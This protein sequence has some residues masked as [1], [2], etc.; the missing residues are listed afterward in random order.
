M[1]KISRVSNFSDVVSPP[2]CLE[3]GVVE[4]SDRVEPMQKVVA[5]WSEVRHP[6]G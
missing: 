4:Q 6:S 2:D 1:N 5:V 3:Q